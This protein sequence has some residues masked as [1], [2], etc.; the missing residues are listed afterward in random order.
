VS[1][2]LHLLVSVFH[3][4]NDMTISRYCV[5]VS[6]DDPRMRNFNYYHWAED[7][8]RRTLMGLLCEDWLTDGCIIVGCEAIA[9]SVQWEAVA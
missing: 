9:G 6:S 2:Y 3:P 8:N 4:E 7:D 1:N 5:G